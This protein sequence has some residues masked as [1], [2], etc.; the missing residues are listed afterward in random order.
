MSDRHAT[1]ASFVDDLQAKGR[2][3]FRRD[4]ALEALAVSDLALKNAARRLTVK[5]RLA[6]P[7]RGFY[8]IVPLEYRVAGAPPPAWFI[9]ALMRFYRRPYYVGL[10]TAASLHGAAHQQPQEFQVVT[11]G[12]L[13]PATAGRSRIR[14][15][16]KKRAAATP[17]VSLKTETGTMRVSTPEATAL[18]LVR[19]ASAAGFLDN[20]SVVLRDLAERIDAQALLAAAREETELAPVQRLGFLLDLVAD[21]KLTEPLATWLRDQRPRSAPLRA[22]QSSSGCRKER[23]WAVAVNQEIEVEE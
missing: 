6:L 10:L 8:V 2:Y 21:A 3:T 22:G 4:E 19:Y 23:R 14:F 18:D 13:R 20:I 9:D 11:D 16:T 1:L 15:F 7:H 17:T 5:G 12:I